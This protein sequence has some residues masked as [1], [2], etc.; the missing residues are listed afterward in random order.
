[1][2]GGGRGR[3]RG[4]NWG[5]EGREER[6]KDGVGGVGGVGAIVVETGESGK[7]DGRGRAIYRG[8]GGGGP[9]MNEMRWGM[10][11]VG[12]RKK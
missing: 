1:M 10:K 6:R 2:E 11:R 4:R 7:D 9:N 12:I 8:G 3:E 5:R